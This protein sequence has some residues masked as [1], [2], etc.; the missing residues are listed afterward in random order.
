MRGDQMVNCVLFYL[1]LCVCFTVI[2]LFTAIQ[3]S[4]HVLT[5]RRTVLFTCTPPT[6]K[7]KI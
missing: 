7:C 5:R 1:C 6:Q 4:V 3:S 2:T